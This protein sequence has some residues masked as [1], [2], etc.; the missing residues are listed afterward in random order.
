MRV[1]KTHEEAVAAVKWRLDLFDKADANSDGK[2]DAA[3]FKE[4]YRL[5]EESLT[6]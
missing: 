2:L 3:E 5:M 1:K 6:E 4:F